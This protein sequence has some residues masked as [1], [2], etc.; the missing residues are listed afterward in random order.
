MMPLPIFKLFIL[1]TGTISLV[2]KVMK[3]SSALFNS[4][5]LRRRSSILNLPRASLSINPRVTPI[6]TPSL[7]VIKRLPFK[8]KK[9]LVAPS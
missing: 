9:L 6:K 5:N 1:T 4:E 2:V 8:I 3:D 7:G